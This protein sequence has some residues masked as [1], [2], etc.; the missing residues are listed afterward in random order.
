MGNNES[1]SPKTKVRRNKVMGRSPYSKAGWISRAKTM[2]LR[3]NPTRT[4]IVVSFGMVLTGQRIAPIRSWMSF[5]L[6]E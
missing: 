6:Q 3:S 4:I 1:L 2:I 5:P